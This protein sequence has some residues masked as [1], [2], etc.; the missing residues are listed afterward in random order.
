MHMSAPS[1][2]AYPPWAE[3]LSR[4]PEIDFCWQEPLARHT[5]FRVGG[6]V[7]CVARPCAE[8]A[9]VQ[10][11]R[12]LRARRITHLVLGAG[13][14]VVAPDDPWEAV[15]IKLDGCCNTLEPGQSGAVPDPAGADQYLTVGSAV[16]LARLTRYC[17]ENA[18]TGLEF[19]VGIPG[20][21][22]G[23]LVMNAG[24]QTGSIEDALCA[25]TMLDA[26][27][28]KNR[29]KKPQLLIGYRSLALPPGTLILSAVLGLQRGVA[30]DIRSRVRTLMQQRRLTQPLNWPSAG[31]I[32]KNPP[33][34]AAGA[35]IERAGLKGMR[36]GDAQVS[37]KHANWIVNLGQARARD[38]VALIKHVEE[39]VYQEFG[40]RL[41][42]EVQ[43]LEA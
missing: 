42:R 31:C 10:L 32:F 19:M 35:L 41:Q 11:L 33:G 27:G 2:R 38:I 15:V 25:I 40:L 37:L 17:L 8:Q 7:T 12:W 28:H 43:V 22:G 20:S 3:A 26:A 9:L 36:L 1:Y 34:Q 13:S 29:V 24:T 14:N 18:L 16:R 30:A 23:A 39:R 21:V 5:T 4:L 6:P